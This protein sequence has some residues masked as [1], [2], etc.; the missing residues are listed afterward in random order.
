[1][2]LQMGLR[3]WAR[4][5][6]VAARMPMRSKPVWAGGNTVIFQRCL[7]ALGG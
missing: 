4:G 5:F 6:V 1:M 7:R 2:L 3:V